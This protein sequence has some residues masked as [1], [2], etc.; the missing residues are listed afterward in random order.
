[1]AKHTF[2]TYFKP[3]PRPKAR[4]NSRIYAWYSPA[5]NS[6]VLG[7]DKKA[8]GDYSSMIYLGEL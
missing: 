6:I 4:R 8:K 1:M 7:I 5:T 2:K 3:W